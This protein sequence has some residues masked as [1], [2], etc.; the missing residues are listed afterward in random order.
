MK[1]RTVALRF[2]LPVFTVLGLVAATT[3]AAS[4]E[5]G[6]GKPGVAAGDVNAAAQILVRGFDNI[7]YG[8]TEIVNLSG[9]T[10]TSTSADIDFS[11]ATL[12]NNNNQLSSIAL[13]TTSNCKLHLYDLPNFST[14]A[15]YTII[16]LGSGG[17]PNLGDCFGANLWKRVNS[18]LLT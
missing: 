5:S 4:G 15:T 6:S 2:V 7:N 1:L 18:L 17:C 8:G 12:G 14:A 9:F 16:P 3:A 11:M 13:S 10:C